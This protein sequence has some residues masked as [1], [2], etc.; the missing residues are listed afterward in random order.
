MTS[1]ELYYAALASVP[2]ILSL[3]GSSQVSPSLLLAARDDQSFIKPIKAGKSTAVYKML[4]GSVPDRGGRPGEI[5]PPMPV[6]EGRRAQGSRG[7]RGGNYQHK[8][9]KKKGKKE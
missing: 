7:G 3:T 6:W 2:S 1:P 4:M 9:R 8:H 5:E